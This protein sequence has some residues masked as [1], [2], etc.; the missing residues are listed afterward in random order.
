MSRASETPRAADSEPSDLHVVIID[1][2]RAGQRIRLVDELILGRDPAA[3][4]LVAGKDVS[5]RHALI[6]REHDGRFTIRDLGSRNGTSVND[7]SIGDDG[8]DLRFGDVIRLG[9]GATVMFAG[10]KPPTEELRGDSVELLAGGVAHNFNN[11]MAVVLANVSYLQELPAPECT[12]ERMAECLEDIEVAA[13]RAVDLTNQLLGYAQLARRSPRIVDLGEIVAGAARS[14]RER[15]GPKHTLAIDVEPELLVR[16][17]GPQVVSAIAALVENGCEAMPDGGELELEARAIELGGGDVA[18]LPEGEY[19]ALRVTDQG[20][21]MAEQVARRAV[22]PFFTT[23]A[24]GGQMGLG[25]TTARGVARA[26]AGDLGL[27]TKPGEGTTVTLYLPLAPSG[28]LETTLETFRSPK[29]IEGL[30]VLL[31]DDEQR[32]LIGEQRLLEQMGCKVIAASDGRQA[33]S[34]FAEHAGSIDVVLLDLIMPEL[35]GA[36]VLR[37]LRQVDESVAVVLVSGHSE[38]DVRSPIHGLRRT[39]AFLGK[40]FDREQLIAALQRVHCWEPKSDHR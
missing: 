28:E 19:A 27:V 3:D 7:V 2:P 9:R 33:L 36:E 17:D 37:R 21:G 15:L 4:V 31:V 24:I 8:V 38:A 14:L 13:R 1:G 11:L 39:E 35:G 12:P 16:L 26:Y 29:A 18:D 23:K 6:R 30:T 10:G 20:C 32:V 5:R 22:K 40:P 34:L 25:L